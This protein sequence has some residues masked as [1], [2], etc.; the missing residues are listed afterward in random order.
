MFCGTINNMAAA[1]NP[2][3]AIRLVFVANEPLGDETKKVV[4]RQV[5]NIIANCM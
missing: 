2:Y 4:W 1:G 3:L 5:I